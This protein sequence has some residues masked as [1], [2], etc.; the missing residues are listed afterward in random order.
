MTD[1]VIGAITNYNWNQVKHW[2]NSL[3]KSGFTGQK[4]LLCYNIDYELAETLSSKGYTIFAFGRDDE[5]GKLTYNKPDFNICLDRFAHIS[6][7]LSRLSNK[8]QY[9]YVIA[10]DVGDVVFQSNPSEWVENNIGDKQLLAASECIRY[11]DENWNKQNMFLSFGPLVSEK[12][13]DRVVYNAGTIAGKFETFVDFCQNIYL[14]SCGAPHNVPGGGGPDQ[15]GMNVLLSMKPY[16][17]ITKFAKSSEG[18]AAQLE[19]M[20]NPHKIEKLKPFIT[21]ELCQIKDG[22]VYT[23]TGKLYALVHQYDVVPELK[24]FIEKEYA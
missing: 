8:E 4:V 9:R 13:D 14:S 11:K 20:A 15:S 7:F 24:E 16:S 17:D 3:D 6:Y 21:E 19:V 12:M 18:W 22:K 2:V 1:I 23:S 10:T 5:K